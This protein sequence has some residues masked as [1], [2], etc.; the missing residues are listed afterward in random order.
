MFVECPNCG[1]EHDVSA[2]VTGDRIW[3]PGCNKWLFV[4]HSVGETILY[5][6]GADDD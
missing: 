3:C 1:Y 5:E 2:R 6:I 4:Q